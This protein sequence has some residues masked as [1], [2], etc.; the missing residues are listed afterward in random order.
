MVS[1]ES[2]Y[3]SYVWI[4]PYGLFVLVTGVFFVRFVFSLPVKTRKLFIISGSIYVLATI[5]FEIPEGRVVAVYGAT[6]YYYLLC[7][8]EEFLEM[9]GVIIFIYALLD[10][11]SLFKPPVQIMHKEEQ[12]VIHKSGNGTMVQTYPFS[13]NQPK[14]L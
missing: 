5:G 11:T 6:S 3:L 4:L 12:F 9:V 2:G 7:S 14:S 8:L 13:S 1:D 10:Y